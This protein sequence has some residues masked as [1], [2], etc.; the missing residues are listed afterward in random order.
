MAFFTIRNGAS[1]DSTIISWNK[2]RIIPALRSQQSWKKNPRFQRFA[3]DAVD[4]HWD[5]DGT[6]VQF[7]K[8]LRS[9]WFLFQYIHIL[10]YPYFSS[11][12]SRIPMCFPYFSHISPDVFSH[13]PPKTSCAVRLVF[14]RLRWPE[15][16]PESLGFCNKN[17]PKLPKF[18]LWQTN[19]TMENHH[20]S[21]DKF[22]IN[23]HF[24]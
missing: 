1:T 3:N 18:T 11:N 9:N 19:I 23:G 5:V 6:L 13:F 12:I 24:Q 10:I 15:R 20:F 17:Q 4:S 14:V 7:S 22:T 8:K 16:F 21:W 2:C